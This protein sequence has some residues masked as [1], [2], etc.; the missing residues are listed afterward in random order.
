[1]VAHS[2]PSAYGALTTGRSALMIAQRAAEEAEAVVARNPLPWLKMIA[3]VA[4][5]ASAL[6]AFTAKSQTRA[7]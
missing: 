7:G 5:A 4:P 3:P 2:A 6:S 1:M